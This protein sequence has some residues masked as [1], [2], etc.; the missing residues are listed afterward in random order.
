MSGLCSM[1]F[2]HFATLYYNNPSISN[3]GS[4]FSWKLMGS[5]PKDWISVQM[6]IYQRFLGLLKKVCYSPK[7]GIRILCHLLVSHFMP[8]MPLSSSYIFAFLVDIS[9]LLRF[10]YKLNFLFA[11]HLNTQAHLKLVPWPVIVYVTSFN[12]LKGIYPVSKK[13]KH[14]VLWAFFHYKGNIFYFKSHVSIIN[15]LHY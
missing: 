7:T 11:T 9:G 3:S 5:Q 12:I 15:V 14:H 6:V 10:K 8:F 2:I 13:Y 4:V 1:F